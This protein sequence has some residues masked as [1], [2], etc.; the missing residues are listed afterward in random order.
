[1]R[2]GSAPASG[3]LMVS[4]D[5]RAVGT[6]TS[7]REPQRAPGIGGPRRGV[8]TDIASYAA[9]MRV[10]GFPMRSLPL[11]ARVLVRLLRGSRTE[12]INDTHDGKSSS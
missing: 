3:P 9:D 7:W 1:M 6:P 8:P 12:L 2:F 5:R 4:G 11:D 10:K